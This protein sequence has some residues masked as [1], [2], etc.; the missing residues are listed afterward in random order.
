MN[1][2]LD[3]ARLQHEIHNFGSQGKTQR[4]QYEEM[5]TPRRQLSTEEIKS[6]INSGI[7]R[8]LDAHLMQRGAVN[9][10]WMRAENVIYKSYT[11]TVSKNI[12][13]M[14][15]HLDK[16]ERD[17]IVSKDKF[18]TYTMSVSQYDGLG[19]FKSQNAIQDREKLA[20]QFAGLKTGN[21]L[22]RADNWIMSNTENTFGGAI[23]DFANFHSAFTKTN[24][25]GKGDPG[26]EALVEIVG[27]TMAVAALTGKVL[28]KATT[29]L[30]YG[31]AK[32]GIK[33]I[34]GTSKGMAR[35]ATKIFAQKAIQET[36][37]MNREILSD[38]KQ[39][40][41]KSLD[42]IEKSQVQKD[43]QQQVADKGIQKTEAVKSEAEKLQAAFKELKDKKKILTNEIKK[44]DKQIASLSKVGHQK[45]KSS[46][47]TKS[48]AQSKTK[49]N[50]SSLKA[51][52]KEELNKPAKKEVTRTETTKATKE[53]SK[54]FNDR[55]SKAKSQHEG[56]SSQSRNAK[57][58]TI[59]KNQQ[60]RQKLL[61]QD[62][63][64]QAQQAIKQAEQQ[65]KAEKKEK[66]R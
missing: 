65:A 26:A 30:A 34:Y 58:K 6:K 8:E 57:N 3:D 16:L 49:P 43:S 54:P 38:K 17:G 2:K 63:Q 11:E 21:M 24:G 62:K 37:K 46:A 33:A 22:E 7:L 9:P 1:E 35:V 28:T 40:L 14:E 13:M 53:T 19:Y 15:K 29:R 23:K 20:G 55:L 5:L 60:T 44:V 27:G 45:A 36:T 31:L 61:G 52:A 56:K 10:K 41:E 47:Q 18:G 42:I 12:S 39:S 51:K 25:W 50:T 64:K 4:E 32:T 66:S 59:K 48:A